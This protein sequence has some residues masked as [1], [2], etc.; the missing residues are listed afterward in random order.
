MSAFSNKFALL[1]EINDKLK[2]IKISDKPTKS[3]KK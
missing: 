1:T 3:L 2:I